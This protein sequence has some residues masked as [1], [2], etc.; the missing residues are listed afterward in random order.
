[1]I[2]DKESVV[3][4]N[5]DAVGSTLRCCTSKSDVGHKISEGVDTIVTVE[6]KYCAVHEYDGYDSFKGSK[7][8]FLD[9]SCTS[10][11]TS[12]FSISVGC[13]TIICS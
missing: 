8:V 1:M 4:G 2:R 13:T 11:F 7:R 5:E 9:F 12:L 3:R 6:G 10:F